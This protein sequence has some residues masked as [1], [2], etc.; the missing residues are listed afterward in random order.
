RAAL[1]RA[2]PRERVAVAGRR[3]RLRLAG[4]NRAGRALPFSRRDAR[5]GREPRTG[6]GLER[7]PQRFREPVR[8]AA[9]RGRGARRGPPR[10]PRRVR[11]LASRG[12]GRRA[13]P[14]E[15]ERHAAALGAWL[16]DALAPRDGVPLP[17]QAGAA[18]EAAEQLLR[19]RLRVRPAA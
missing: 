6:C 8:P 11:G 1:D 3:R 15:P 4:R 14:P 19:R 10:P 16:P 2:L 13:P 5:R 12:G 7:R 17:A 18:L 9:E